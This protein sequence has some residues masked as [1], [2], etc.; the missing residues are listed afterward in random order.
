MILTRELLKVFDLLARELPDKV[1]PFFAQDLET[2]GGQTRFSLVFRE[3]VE[4]VFQNC[5]LVDVSACAD[6]LKQKMDAENAVALCKFFLF[7]K[8][9]TIR[10]FIRFC[11]TLALWRRI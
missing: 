4:E 2:V 3:Y 7:C 9:R 10:H 8:S 5:W 1:V 11:C 6:L